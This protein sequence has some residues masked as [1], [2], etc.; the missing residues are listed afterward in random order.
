MELYADLL[1]K[2][3]EQGRIQVTFPDIQVEKT[4][5]SC[6]YQA[7]AKIRGILENDTYSDAVCCQKIE[8]IVRV[9]ESLGSN[10][11]T[12]HDFG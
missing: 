10:C 2:L 3:L 4:L 8:E 6:C 12:R 7:L 9:Y 5:E 11:G 1:A